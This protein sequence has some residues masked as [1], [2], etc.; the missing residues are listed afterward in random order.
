MSKV[1]F[2][3]HLDENSGWGTAARGYLNALVK[4]GHDIVARSIKPNPDAQSI[5]QD[6]VV[7]ECLAKSSQGCEINIQHLLPHMMV[8][9]GNFRKNI[10]LF[11]TESNQWWHSGWH[12]YLNQ[13]DEIWVP[14]DEMVLDHKDN[15][16]TPPVKLVPHAFDV[17][18][19]SNP[20]GRPSD[21]FRFYF[22]GENI[23]RKRIS[24]VV[25]AFHLAFNRSDPVE[26][27]IKTSGNQTDIED[28]CNKV[29]I[30]LKLYPRTDNYIKERIITNRLTDQEMQ[31]LHL[32]CN[33]FVSASYGEAW[34]IP[35]FDAMGYGN[36]VIHTYCGGPIDFLDKYVDGHLVYGNQIPCLGANETFDFLNTGK[37]T[38]TSAY[39]LQFSEKMREVYESKK[40]NPEKNSQGYKIAQQYSYEAVG[41]KIKELLN[42]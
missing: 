40:N 8:P 35:A 34:N 27:V 32:A 23:V 29:K 25:Q 1:L 18:R 21:V 6:E 10:G 9:N 39:I 24:G 11:V 4:S 36:S 3:G 7:S 42:V 30:G 28:I 14:N 20:V 17:S 33:C 2:I 26:L 15:K 41:Q 13:M 37:E 22:I 31:D 12:R 16:L 19:Y 5:E 38:W